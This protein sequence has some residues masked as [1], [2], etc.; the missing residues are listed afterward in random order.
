M[1]KSFR[2]SLCATALLVGVG[3]LAMAQP[4]GSASGNPTSGKAVAEAK[5]AACHGADGNSTDP[6]IPKLAGQNPAYLYW[7]LWAFKRGTRRSDVMSG[8]AGPLSDA[9]MA[10]AAAFYAGQAIRPDSVKGRRLAATGPRIFAAG[11]G[12]GMMTACAMC[13]GSGGRGGMSGMMGMMGRGGMMGMMGSGM[14][15]IPNLNG[16]HAAYVIDQ[17]DRFAASERQGMMMNRIAATLSETDKKAVAEY[18][19][20]LR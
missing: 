3:P 6:K 15:N 8:I 4:Y 9:E 16:Q 13:H 5:C 7:Q 1:G 10:D 11:A 17:L 20:G 19:S 2:V 18:L 12:P 14:A